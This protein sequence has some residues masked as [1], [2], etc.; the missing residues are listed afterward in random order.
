MRY[1]VSASDI[2]SILGARGRYAIL[3]NKFDGVVLNRPAQ[4]ISAITGKRKWFYDLD[5]TCAFLKRF[6][7]ATFTTEREKKLRAMAEALNVPL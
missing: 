1:G 4:L 2:D 6:A 5:S 3:R 7:P